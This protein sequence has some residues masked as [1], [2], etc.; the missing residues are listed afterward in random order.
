MKTIK[1]W[2]FAQQDRCLRH[3]DG[4][5]IIKGRNL[6]VEGNPILCNYGL[7]A[8]RKI[9][10][11]LAKSRGPIICKVEIGGKIDEDSKEL[12]GQS[13]KCLWWVDAEKLLH[14]FACKCAARALKKTNTKTSKYWNAIKVKREWL[15]GKA[16]DDELKDV[17]KATYRVVSSAAEYAANAAA[18]LEYKTA[19]YW[20]AG[21]AAEYADEYADE[22]SYDLKASETYLKEIK[23][24][25]KTLLRMVKK[26]IK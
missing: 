20:A 9:M 19:A 15:A 14:E 5:K 24:Q 23:W 12:A 1:A 16:T 4:R 3:G 26:E 22:D 6:K 13:R 8:S 2:H 17:R 25:E 10:D 11:A 7:H 21:Y 18:N